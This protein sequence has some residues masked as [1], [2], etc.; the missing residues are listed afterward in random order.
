MACIDSCLLGSIL[1][2]TMIINMF[3]T[4]KDKVFIDFQK[5]L[6]LEQKK[7]YSNIVNE[8]LKIYLQGYMLGLIF[9]FLFIYYSNQTKMKKVC[10]FLT[11]AISIKI[12]YYRLTPKTTYMLEHLN[13]Q[14]QNKAWLKIYKHMSRKW[15]F[16]AILG[17]L[18]YLSL[19]SGLC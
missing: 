9:A 3:S 2:G 8:R 16:G 13:S 6:S 11:I 4:H 5:T 14:E 19:G 12:L 1:V 18:G 15:I 10:I 17:G 7:I